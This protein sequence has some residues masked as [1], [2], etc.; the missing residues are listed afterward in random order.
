MSLDEPGS[1]TLVDARIIIGAFGITEKDVKPE[2][3]KPNQAGDKMRDGGLD[4]FFFVGGYPAGAIAELAASG[5]G[6]ELVPITGAGDRQDARPVRFLRARHDPCQHLQ[7]RRRGE[8]AR[9]RRA[10]GHFGQGRCE[11]IYE[12]TKA[13]W[14]GNTRKLL[15]GGHAKGK[16]ITRENAVAG[17]GI[18]FHPGAEKFYKEAG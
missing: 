7:G 18:P 16:A 1:G 10:V 2:Y 3:L 6:I 17:A 5:G 12:V 14:N 13:L 4:A 11:L 9:R 15:D 8:D